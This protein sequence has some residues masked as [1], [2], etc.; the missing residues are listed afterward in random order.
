MLEKLLKLWD[1]NKWLFLL[2]LP[3]IIVLLVTKAMLVGTATKAENS[4]KNT[5]RRDDNLKKIQEKA[6]KD[7]EEEIKKAEELKKKEIKD[8][9]NWHLK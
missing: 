5:Q 1:S 4:I 3:V 8:D 6:N 9:E 7:A 2:A